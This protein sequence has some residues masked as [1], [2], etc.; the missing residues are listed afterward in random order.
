MPGDGAESGHC[1]DLLLT[2]YA[3]AAPPRTRGIVRSATPLLI[4]AGATDPASLG[5]RP[6]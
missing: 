2:A 5:V 6:T 1:L 3:I 4:A